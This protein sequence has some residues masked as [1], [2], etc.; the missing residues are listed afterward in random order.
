[1]R[2][3]HLNHE[4]ARIVGLSK[5]NHNL[6]YNINYERASYSFLIAAFSLFDDTLYED[7]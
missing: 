6:E 2:K 4:S 3:T 1:M 7:S 5:I